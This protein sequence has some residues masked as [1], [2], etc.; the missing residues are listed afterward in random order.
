MKYLAVDQLLAV[1]VLLLTTS[2]ALPVR[3]NYDLNSKSRTAP[4]LQPLR[5]TGPF[6]EPAY[7]SQAAFCHP[8]PGDTIRG[9][10]VYWQAGDG[11]DIPAIFIAHSAKL[12]III[13]SQG[14]NKTDHSS[15]MNVSASYEGKRKKETYHI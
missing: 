10:Q 3:P 11:T 1:L 12:G 6:I 2:L 15:I 5:D 8:H 9:A 13:S 7:F 4:H 14:T